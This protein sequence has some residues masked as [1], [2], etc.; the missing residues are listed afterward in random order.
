MD[1]LQGLALRRG[2]IYEVLIST[3]S[4]KAPHAAPIGIWTED[5]GTLL[6][7]LYDKSETLANILAQ[8]QFVANFPADAL[9]L[10]AALITPEHLRF[11]PARS[12]RA[13]VVSGSVAV[14]ELTLDRATPAE[15]RVRIAA[16]V[17]SAQFAERPRLINRAEELLLE[18]LVAATRVDLLGSAAVRA[19]ITENHRVVRKVA[20]GSPY[21]SALTELL[22]SLDTS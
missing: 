7:D 14:V 3:F 16:H 10:F 18:S 13:P 9:T 8:G 22:R 6:M 4:G 15:D 1:H 21:E 5:A 20:P 19:T 17:V 2:W 12:V 11:E